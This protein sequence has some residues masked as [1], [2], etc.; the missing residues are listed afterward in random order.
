MKTGGKFGEPLLG[1][2]V[3]ES[4][5]IAILRPSL[6]GPNTRRLRLQTDSQEEFLFLIREAATL[7]WDPF[8]Q[9]RKHCWGSY[10]SVLS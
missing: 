2:K 10:S 6:T 9:R 7:R 1:Q 3:S 8:D 4:D 5:Q